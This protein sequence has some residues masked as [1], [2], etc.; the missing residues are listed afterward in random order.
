MVEGDKARRPQA[1]LFACGQNMIRS[2]M[3][4]AIFRHLYGRRAYVQSAGVKAGQLDP[5]AV[6]AMNEMDLDISK[7]RPRTF[8]ELE[9][10]EGLNFDLVVSL[11]PEAHHK[12]LNLTRRL[13]FEVEYWPTLDPST[14]EGTRDQRMDVYRQTR[15]ALM[16]RIRD[17]FGAPGMGNE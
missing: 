9:D 1:V 17:R 11:A 13:P 4:E 7:H 14:V 15:D 8:E 10:W 5:F 2:P 16:R 12:A 6:A 3:A